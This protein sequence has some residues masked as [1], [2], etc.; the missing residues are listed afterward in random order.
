MPK[1]L[2]VTSSMYTVREVSVLVY[3]IINADGGVIRS[4]LK[5]INDTCPRVLPGVGIL[6]RF[7][8][9]TAVC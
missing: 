9:E 3:R 1:N 4:I 2:A 5:D 6:R 7:E 8:N